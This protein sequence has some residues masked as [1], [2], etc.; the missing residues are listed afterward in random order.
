MSKVIKVKLDPQSIA[1]AINEIQAYK[2]DLERR[3][4]ILLKELINQG[5]DIARAKV[6]DFGIIHDTNLS[7]SIE[8]FVFGNKGFIFVDDI[9]AVFFEFGTGPKGASDPHPLSDGGYKS[10][11]W[12]TAADG[13]PMDKLYG[14]LPL[15]HPDGN[16]YYY[17]TGQKAKPFMYETAIQLRDEFPEI[18]RKVFG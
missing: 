7:Q 3:V 17:T 18:V 6:V 9:H 10:E 12:Y 8:G 2:E 4:K 1:D 14:W 5:V 15:K 13:K 11:G 16:T